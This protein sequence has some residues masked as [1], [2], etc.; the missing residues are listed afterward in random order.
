MAKK[1]KTPLTIFETVN[2]PDFGEIFIKTHTTVERERK[3]EKG[4]RREMKRLGLKIPK[5]SKYWRKGD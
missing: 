4:Y 2:L 3:E 1:K 5:T